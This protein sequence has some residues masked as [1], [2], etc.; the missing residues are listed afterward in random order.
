MAA[1]A[2]CPRK[3]QAQG[4]TVPIRNVHAQLPHQ[5]RGLGPDG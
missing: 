1:Q 2:L 4:E 5:P 3:P